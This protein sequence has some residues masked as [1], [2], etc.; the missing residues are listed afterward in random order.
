[1]TASAPSGF[2][3]LVTR[4]RRKRD[5][6][7]QHKRAVMLA[8]IA[9]P[10]V[11]AHLQSVAVLDL[12]AN[13]PVPTLL[14]RLVSEPV[15]IQELSLSSSTGAIRA[16]IYIPH[17]HPDAP[18]MVVLHGVHYLGIDEPRLIAFSSAMA[19]CGLRVLTPELPGIK[20]YHVGANSIATIGDA[21]QWMSAHDGNRPVGV[22][23]LSFSGGLALMAAADPRWHASIKFVVAIGS[24][25][26]M[27]RVATFYRTG[28]DALPGGGVEK[29]KPH[30]YGPLV[31]EYESLEDFVPAADVSALRA[32]LRAHLYEDGPAEK[33]ALAAL[34]PAQLAEAH[35]LMDTTSPATRALLAHS[36]TLHIEDMAGVSPHGHLQQLTTPVYLLHGAGDDIIPSAETRWMAEELPS[37]SLKAE[38]ISPVLSHVNLD[39][40]NPTAM[41]QWRLV[42]FFALI[43]HAAESR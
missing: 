43:L 19:S 29:L 12:V 18:A 7:K 27:S 9:E 28:A 37:A 10:F 40:A 21:A 11:H 22:M 23:G 5:Q 17:D 3:R 4:A 38:L 13:K 25:D 20:D 42:H 6:L 2:S 41:D 31:L 1:M 24:Q 30:D 34:T 33:A 8:V 36:E 39:G 35:A 15:T 32:V 16:R 14:H 26:E